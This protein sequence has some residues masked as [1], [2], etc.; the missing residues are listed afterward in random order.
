MKNI[1]KAWTYKIENNKYA[2]YMI[3]TLIFWLFIGKHMY[4]M[5]TKWDSVATGG[6][7][8]ITQMYPV[9]VYTRRV[10]LQFF[11]SL[12][13]GE[14]FSFP[15]IEWTLG[16]GDNTI[17]ALNWHGFGDPLYFFSIFIAEDSLPYF[18]TFLFYLKV[19]L[20]GVAFIAFVSYLAKEKSL[21]AYVIGALIYCFT[22]FTVQC[23]MHII[24][25]H[26][27]MFVPL[28][29]LGA[30]RSMDG[31]RRGVLLLSTFG[32]ALCGFFF[33]YIGSVSLA[34]YVIYRL[35]RRKVSF[36]EA[37]RRIGSMLA[38]YFVGLGLAGFIFIP[39]VYGF[40]TST[41]MTGQNNL[42]LFASWDEIKSFFINTFFPQYSNFQVMSVCTIGIFSVVLILFGR[43]RYWEK[44]VLLLML[45]SCFIPYI[46]CIMSGFGEVYDR[47][48]VVY[49]LYIAYLTTIIWDEL[50]EL[51]WGQKFAA[52]AVY[53]LIG[54]VGKKNHIITDDRY[55]QA[56]I[57]YGLLLCL[58]WIVFPLCKRI[59][60][61][62]I[63]YICAFVIV[64]ATILKSWTTVARDKQIDYL[65]ERNVVTELVNDESF[66]R[67]ENERTFQEERTGLNVAFRLDYPG[68]GE[69]YS[70]ENPD[71][72]KAMKAWNVSS[73]VS[74]YYVGL[75]MRAVLESLAVVK[76]M[77]LR[78]GDSYISPYGFEK[79]SSTDDMEWTLYQNKYV[80]PIAYSYQEVY[81]YDKYEQLDGFLKQQIMLRSAA[82]E[83][84]DGNLAV[85][86]D[87]AINLNEQAFDVISVENGS[88]EEGV[89]KAENGTVLT[90]EMLLHA[91]CENYL[92]LFS[93][94]KQPDNAI[95]VVVDKDDFPY[96]R[97]DT[98][99]DNGEIGVYLGNVL[100][101]EKRKVIITFNTP[102]EV[103]LKNMHGAYYDFS[104]YEDYIEQRKVSIKAVDVLDNAVRVETESQSDEIVCV[105]VPYS[106]GWSAKIDGNTAKIYKM[107]D[108]Y[109]GI[110][111]PAGEHIVELNYFTPGLKLGIYISL[112]CLVLII[113][114]ELIGK[115]N[116]K[117]GKNKSVVA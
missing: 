62:T 40:L 52:G 30:E 61:K 46:S 75:D 54:I 20:G 112:I 47:W 44:S 19:Y 95:S 77:V 6:W 82:V 26:T 43:K 86:Q 4:N 14:G 83:D 94:E 109:M 80:L 1:I 41:R 93:E 29:F 11:H 97:I 24:F 38:E 39:A 100:Q 106:K 113:V 23:N 60:R 102:I 12:S 36:R 105:A 114:I 63:A 18:Y 7:D 35:I 69:Y 51:S 78:T 88:I 73:E 34:F 55:S 27:M 45:I 33:L 107:N 72:T 101:D 111:V 65:R 9:M 56:I 59:N 115:T 99:Y 68:V 81:P 64:V 103:N 50:C 110:E 49:T 84:Y 32:F 22:G 57:A 117:A 91:D 79:V 67:V 92:T 48:E 104:N 10:L 98:S 89:V 15:M 66:Y 17:S 71:Y 28:L 116:I 108:M 25:T 74:H 13:N 2:K 76:Y 53:L 3:F 16:M 58:I 8:G 96:G 42:A 90:I 31:K 70:I 21:F 85:K 5:A 37:I 87:A